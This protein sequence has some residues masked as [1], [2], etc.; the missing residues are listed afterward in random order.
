MYL[1]W[2]AYLFLSFILGTLIFSVQLNAHEITFHSDYF[3]FTLWQYSH[4]STV[5][6]NLSQL[7][8]REA[9]RRGRGRQ[10]YR[11]KGEYEVYYVWSERKSFKNNSLERTTS[12][13]AREDGK[14]WL[15]I[16]L[17]FKAASG[18]YAG[19]HLGRKIPGYYQCP[20]TSSKNP[21][22]LVLENKKE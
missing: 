20:E 22:S 21:D 7:Y 12:L 1:F 6:W 11:R 13:L 2:F 19:A 17:R 14:S 9:S 4:I 18:A 16:F 10:T 5:S 8:L 3:I 15:S